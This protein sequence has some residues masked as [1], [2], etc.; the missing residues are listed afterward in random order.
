[1]PGAQ[2]TVVEFGIFFF[3]AVGDDAARTYRLVLDAARKADDLGF[4]F[5]STPERHFHRFGGA[6][7]NPAVTSAMIAAVT[8]KVQ[9]RAGSVVTPLH[10]AVRIVE[11]FAMVDSLSG[12]RAAISVGSGWNVNDFVIASDAYQTR[13]ERMTADL[14][15]IRRAWRDGKW[16][17]RNPLGHEV[18][19]DVFPRP[20][21]A[22]LPVWITASRS[23]ET[24][25]AAGR[26][27]TNLLTHLENQDISELADKIDGY[28]EAR[29]EAGW[30][31]DGRVTLM[32]HT[33]VAPTTEQA[34]AVARPWLTS[35]VRRAIDLEAM[36]VNSGGKMSGGRDAGTAMAT[37]EARS[38]LAEFGVN[39]YLD[40]ASLIGSVAEC[41]AIAGKVHAAGVDEIACL[42]D[43]V[44]DPEVVLAG[45]EELAKVRAECARQ[46]VG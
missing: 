22:E 1:M 9:I 31:G 39:R 46:T 42:V 27:G 20:V 19:L 5:V 24:F 32:M 26:L 43:F 25:Q 15:L 37:E 34:R 30:T 40:G 7:P 3:A 18:E 6:F 29:R 23:A 11:D 28:R 44:D 35:Y 8:E 16:T 17:A 36:A 10:P 12:G 33:F 14:D 41:A 45:I 4:A 13:R 38:R 2:D 21:S